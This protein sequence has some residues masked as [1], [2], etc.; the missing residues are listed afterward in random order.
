MTVS[1][2]FVLY[3]NGISSG[4]FNN[5]SIADSV[6]ANDVLLTINDGDNLALISGR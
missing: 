5:L 2:V 6:F 1:F 4:A 3:L